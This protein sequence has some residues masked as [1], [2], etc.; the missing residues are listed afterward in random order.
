MQDIPLGFELSAAE[1][2]FK[3]KNRPDLALIHSQVP[4]RAAGVFTTNLFQA[5]PVL[6]ARKN[7]NRAEHCRAILVNAGQANA[8]TGKQGLMDCT[9]S[10]EMAAELLGTRLEEILPASTGVIGVR[11]PM[12]LW[13]ESL[14]ALVRGLGESSGQDA[15][16]AIMTTDTFPKTTARELDLQGRRVRFWGMAKGAGMISPSMATMLAFIL[17]DLEVARRDWSEMLFAAVR[18]TFNA[19]TVDGDTSTNDCVLALANGASGSG[20][21]GPKEVRNVAMLIKDLCRDLAYQI[22]RDAEGGTKVMH[23][24]VSGAVSREEAEL[25]ARAVGN[26]CLVK[27]AMYG[28]DPNWGR[29]VAALGRSWARF[30]PD[31]IRVSLAGKEIFA[32]GQPV[33]MD[34]D[35]VFAPLLDSR[36]IQVDIDLGAGEGSYVLLASDLTEEYIRINADYRS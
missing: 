33:D 35:L 20:P 10:L 1:A 32:A 8:C 18:D 11:M 36:D 34:V 26:S 9:R 16:R 14:P 31:R 15:A 17:T 22:V 2:G 4:A 24:L 7:L 5:A 6:T 29:I 21:E 27:T 12:H 25:A 3:Y 19:I 30:D 28:K 23:I 13:Q